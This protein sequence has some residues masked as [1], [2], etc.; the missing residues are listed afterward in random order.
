M[1]TKVGEMF[2]ELAV[3]AASGNLSVKQMVGALGE[4]DVASV[5]SVGIFAKLGEA[6]WGMAKAATATAVELTALQQITGADPKI[7]NQWEMAA[8]RLHIS[9][10]SIVGAITAV[11]NIQKQMESG[12]GQ[13]RFMAQYGIDATKIVD[14]KRAYKDLMDYV[15]EFSKKGGRYQ[16]LGPALQQTM[17]DQMF[18]GNANDMFR[19]IE[20]AKT[21]QF[22][23]EQI[24]GLNDRQVADLNK[25]DSQWIAIK[26]DVV[27]IFDKFLTASGGM[28]ELLHGIQD[29]LGAVTRLL[30][31]TTG[32]QIIEGGGQMAGGVLSDI[33]HPMR[34]AGQIGDFVSRFHREGTMQEDLLRTLITSSVNAMLPKEMRGKEDSK[35]TVDIKHNGR[36]VTT[37]TFSGKSITN[38][39]ME[40]QAAQMGLT[41]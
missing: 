11:W 22:H 38:G 10:Q 2:I 6:L 15:A 4:L 35:L 24:R 1:A 31:T 5:T 23:P 8:N 19:L 13:P 30:E 9:S 12:G 17:L 18:G 40:V 41:P 7:V 16:T 29:L 37:K 3:D 26:T 20:A 25:L 28:S 33:A 39:D 21:G 36:T 32:K 27:G 14:G 34:T